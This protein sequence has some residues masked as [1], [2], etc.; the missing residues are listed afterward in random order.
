MQAIVHR[1][2]PI[3]KPHVVQHSLASNPAAREMIRQAYCR[4]KPLQNIVLNSLKPSKGLGVLSKY[5]MCTSRSPK[6]G[7]VK[8]VFYYSLVQSVGDDTDWHCY[9]NRVQ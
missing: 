9:S 3:L 1:H 8:T 7:V 5:S 6:Q 4:K 2:I